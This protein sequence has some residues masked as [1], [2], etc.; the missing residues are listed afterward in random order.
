[1]AED[2]EAPAER[3]LPDVPVVRLVEIVGLPF[4]VDF[5]VVGVIHLLVVHPMHAPYHVVIR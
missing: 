3:G 2:L 4:L 1:M 5:E